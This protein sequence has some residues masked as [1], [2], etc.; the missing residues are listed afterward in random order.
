[1]LPRADTLGT[2]PVSAVEAP[3]PVKSS[4]DARQEIYHRLTQIELGRQFQ[5]KVLKQLDDGTFIVKIADTQARVVLPKE[6]RVGDAV[7]MSMLTAHPRPVFLLHDEGNSASTQLSQVGRMI[8]SILQTA[9]DQNAPLELR[10]NTPLLNTGQTLLLPEGAVRTAAAMQQAIADSGLFYE[11][12]LEEWIAGSRNATDLGREPQSSFPRSHMPQ[13][14][15][16]QEWSQLLNHLKTWNGSEQGL[17]QF[18]RNLPPQLKKIGTGSSTDADTILSGPSSQESF[19]PGAE[20][21]RTVNQQLHALENRQVLWQGELWPGQKLEWEVTD[22][23]PPGQRGESDEPAWRSSV[24]FSLPLLGDV[25]AS[26]YLHG[27]DVQISVKASSEAAA[28]FLSAHGG[29]LAEALASA[30]ASLR[31]FKVSSDEKA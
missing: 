28:D 3:L 17:M 18:L 15:I 23:T 9:K 26:I 8:S 20:T 11:A 29:M 12:H 19:L 22:D 4:G 2:R 27:S 24:R 1:M 25:S 7:L 31:S 30:G 16:P 10:G 5:A 14:D 13:E 21:V 6:A